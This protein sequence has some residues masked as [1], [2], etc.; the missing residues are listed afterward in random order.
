MKIK[1]EMDRRIKKFGIIDEKLA[2]AAAVFLALIVA[3]YYPEILN[4]NVWW[5]V[6][7]LAISAIKPLYVFYFKK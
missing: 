5:F 2:Q 1:A 7:L 3:K 6:A 4:I